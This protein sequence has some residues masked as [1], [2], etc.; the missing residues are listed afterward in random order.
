MFIGGHGGARDACRL[1][2]RTVQNLVEF[3]A[4]QVLKYDPR[5]ASLLLMLNMIDKRDVN[6][7]CTCYQVH[8]AWSLSAVNGSSRCGGVTVM[9]ITNVTS[10]GLVFQ[11][12]QS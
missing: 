8:V 5:F 11:K 7:L 3:H 10:V 2:P 9:A 1:M 12:H 6:H 4:W